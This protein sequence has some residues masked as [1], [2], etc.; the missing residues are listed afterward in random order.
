MEVIG[1]IE[2]EAISLF[3]ADAGA[4]IAIDISLNP[5]IFSP[6]VTQELEINLIVVLLEHIAIR[7][8]GNQTAN[9]LSI[10]RAEIRK[11]TQQKNLLQSSRT[12]YVIKSEELAKEKIAGHHSQNTPGNTDT[13]L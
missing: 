12:K 8:L 4:S 2:P 9:K 13:Q 6:N 11:T 1:R 10:T 3:P 7:H 5:P